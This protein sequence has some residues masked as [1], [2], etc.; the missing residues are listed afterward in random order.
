[1]S[2]IEVLTGN[3]LTVEQWERDIAKTYIGKMIWKP[4]MG[5]GDMAMIQVKMDLTKKK[6]D[7]ITIGI[8]GRVV[9]GQVTGNSKAIGNE[10][11]L[12]FYNQ[13]LVVDNVRRAVK[14]EDV[15]MSE[16]RTMFSVLKQAREALEDEFAEDL[17]NDITT[18]MMGDLST[19]RVQGR[20]LYGIADSN[21]NAT[22]ATAINN[23][24]NTSDKFSTKMISV[25]RRKADIPVNAVNKIRPMRVV[26]GKN[27]EEWYTLF[28][29]GYCIRDLTELDAAWINA[30]LN[31]PPRMGPANPI[32]TGSHFKGAWDGVLVYKHDDLD[33][34]TNT[35]S[36]TV[37]FAHNILMGA[38]AGAVTWAQRAKFMEE[39]ADF[40]HD[41]S[42]E[43]HEI[44]TQD[45]L[46]FSS[47]DG[48]TQED[49]GVVNVFAAA[50]AD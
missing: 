6:G 5:M 14:I 36:T 40:K 24:D 30:Q 17:D 3:G 44:R 42:Y 18:A 23:I 26:M 21:Y 38:Q 25:A 15:P 28:A 27:F 11:T 12:T 49:N 9:G 2:F 29:H 45:K 41:V 16:Q 32:F 33:L 47:T 37:Q 19:G 31:I 20:Y 43:L 13:R 10:G 35:S 1:M 34:A 48:G 7:A 39:M 4:F 50:V 8:R 46:V 22:H